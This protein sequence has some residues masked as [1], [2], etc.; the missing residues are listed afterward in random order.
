MTDAENE[1]AGRETLLNKS[2]MATIFGKV[3]PIYEVHMQICNKL[4]SLV[5]HWDEQRLLGQEWASK[6]RAALWW[7]LCK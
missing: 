5:S 1:K 4:K 2:E 7:F 3:T 6:V